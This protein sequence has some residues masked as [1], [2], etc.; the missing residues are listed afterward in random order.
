MF[1]IM[2]VLDDISHLDQIL[3]AWSKQGISGATIIES[4]GLYR[5]QLKRIPM[6][7]AYGGAPM[8]EKGNIT[9]LVIVE[10][11]QKVQLCLKEIEQIV[12][13]LDGPNTGVFSAWPLTI[14]KGIPLG[15]TV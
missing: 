5:R 13:D 1:M 2:F 15:G 3:D 6:R 8:E 14:T 4:T 11:E 10:N 12:G 7:Y 9:L